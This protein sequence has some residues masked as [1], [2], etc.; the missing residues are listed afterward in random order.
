MLAERGREGRQEGRKEE[1]R[2]EGGAQQHW[3]KVEDEIPLGQ[4][5]TSLLLTLETAHFEPSSQ[6]SRHK[7]KAL[8]P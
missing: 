2:K 8:P 5:L 7:T 4:S 6:S 1:G 3:R